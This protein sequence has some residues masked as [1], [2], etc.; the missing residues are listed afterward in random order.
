MTT[1]SNAQ[2]ALSN[3]FT[4]TKCTTE[5]LVGFGMELQRQTY[6]TAQGAASG[7]KEYAFLNYCKNSAVTG[8]WNSGLTSGGLVVDPLDYNC[9]TDNSTNTQY[10]SWK[11]A[12]ALE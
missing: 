8:T 3:T 6:L 4:E 12:R 2:Y 7:G 11:T 5:E 9:D 1:Y 10:T